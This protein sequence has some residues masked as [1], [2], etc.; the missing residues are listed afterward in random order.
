MTTLTQLF[1]MVSAN[2]YEGLNQLLLNNKLIELNSY[3]SGQSLITRAIEVRAKECFDI[4]IDNPNNTMI[5]NKHARF[6]G[7]EKA[8]DYYMTAPNISN[9]YYVQRLL[10]KGVEVE[11][12]IVCKVINN[13]SLFGQLFNRIPN[14][15][16]NLS[17]I[18]YSSVDCNNMNVFTMLYKKILELN[19]EEAEN[20]YLHQIIFSK[21]IKS[22][23]VIVIESIKQN[24][25]WKQY[26][27]YP[28]IYHTVVLND[29][30]L[31]DYF[32]NNYEKLNEEQLNQI[33]NIYNIQYILGNNYYPTINEKTFNFMKYSL[34]KIYKLPIKFNDN[35]SCI[36][37][38]FKSLLCKSYYHWEYKKLKNYN[39]IFQLMYWFLS[40]GAV[41]SNPLSLLILSEV[42]SYYINNKHILSK[43]PEKLSTYKNFFKQFLYLMEHFNYY[44]EKALKDEF[45]IYYGKDNEANWA[46]EKQL[47]INNLDCLHSTVK[48]TRKTK[49]D[50]EV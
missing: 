14:D 45:Q 28:I 39:Y 10:E 46:E 8:L 44:P 50:I 11:P 15:M 48:K 19:L 27:N 23:N 2:D 20:T 18:L 22:S 36:I 7:L 40:N 42:D 31:F 4:I 25:D 35:A 5:K 43:H 30:I 3:K 34:E 6:N 41:H 38:L 32:Y 37:E 17:L 16:T 13:Q 47:F 26:D 29:K 24:I 21:A 12:N 1:K 9:E 49:K 33:P